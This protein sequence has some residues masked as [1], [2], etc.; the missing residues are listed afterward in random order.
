MTELVEHR[1]RTLEC[2]GLNSVQGSSV[3][4]KFLT[5]LVLM[6]AFVLPYF[7]LSC[8]CKMVHVCVHVL[9]TSRML[10]IVGRA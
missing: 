10:R 1:S 3:S 7:F 6:S 9:Y 4:K 8:T 5:V 2:A